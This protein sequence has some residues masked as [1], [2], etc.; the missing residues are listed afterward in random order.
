MLKAKS[1][2]SGNLLSTFFCLF[3]FFLGTAVKNCREQE[4][5]NKHDWERVCGRIENTQVKQG[6]H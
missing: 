2:L 1:N 5:I 4:D 3:G 6:S